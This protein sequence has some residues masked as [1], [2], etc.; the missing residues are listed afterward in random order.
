MHVR[1]S[2]LAWN[3]PEGLVPRH[4]QGNFTVGMFFQL[5]LVGWNEV[6]GSLQRAQLYATPSGRKVDMSCST[7]L[8]LERIKLKR[9]VGVLV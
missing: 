3:P 8:H 6:C 7:H 1:P 2:T 4:F 9:P 5:V